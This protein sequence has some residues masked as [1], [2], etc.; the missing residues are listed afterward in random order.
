MEFQMSEQLTCDISQYVLFPRV[1]QLHLIFVWNHSNQTPNCA[2][3]RP[4]KCLSVSSA[5]GGVALL[6]LKH[7]PALYGFSWRTSRVPPYLHPCVDPCKSEVLVN[8]LVEDTVHIDTKSGTHVNH[9]DF[10]FMSLQPNPRCAWTC[11]ISRPSWRQAK[12]F[13]FLGPKPVFHFHESRSPGHL[14]LTPKPG[15]LEYQS[16]NLR[17]SHVQHVQPRCQHLSLIQVHV[18]AAFQTQ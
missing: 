5:A 12:G 15:R 9:S 8:E 13:A 10:N 1:T 11:G 17:L 2:Q 7:L 16:S 18:T 3:R 14:P 6:C 4:T